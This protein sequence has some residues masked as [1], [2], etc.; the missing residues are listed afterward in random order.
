MLN[1]WVIL[2]QLQGVSVD[3]KKT[4]A[5]LNWP[6]PKDVKGLR[7]FLGLIGY[8]H[9]FVKGYDTLAKPLTGLT[10]KGGWCLFYQGRVVLPQNSTHIPV[11]LEEFHSTAIGGHLGFLRTYK[12]LAAIVFWRGMRKDVKAFVA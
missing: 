6:V 9:R 4:E 11:L 2:C 5:M 7:G 3:P 12:R 10:K 1:I 8:F